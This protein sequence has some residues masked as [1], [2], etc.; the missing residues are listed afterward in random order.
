MP[1]VGINPTEI[2]YRRFNDWLRGELRRT[3]TKQETLAEYIGIERDCLSKRLNDKAEWKFREILKA[4]WYFDNSID[5]NSIL[6]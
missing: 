6:G 5:L 1:R 4:V 3:H 2:R